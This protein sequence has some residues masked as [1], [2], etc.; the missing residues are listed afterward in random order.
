MKKGVL[1]FS[2]TIKQTIQ[3]YIAVK[4]QHLVKVKHQLFVQKKKYRKTEKNISNPK[5][6]G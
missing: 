4:Q 1:D 3:Q 6:Q 2:Q 5:L